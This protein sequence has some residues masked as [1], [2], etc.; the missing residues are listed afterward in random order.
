MA[1]RAVVFEEF[2]GVPVV[3]EVPEPSPPPGGVVLRVEAT[4]LCR[5]DWHGWRGHD[6]GIVL[7]HGLAAHD[8]PA[9]LELV[10]SG[11]VRPDALVSRE[12]GLADASAALVELDHGSPTG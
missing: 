5:S 12:I 1:V 10:R 6:P 7:P 9:L 4:G 2:G 8:Y 3:T 11:V